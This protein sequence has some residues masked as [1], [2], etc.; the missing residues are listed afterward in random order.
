MTQE[1]NK[2]PL[3]KVLGL[4]AAGSWIV[5]QVVDVLTQNMGLPS[6]VFSFAVVLLVLGLP[7]VGATAYLSGLRSGTTSDGSATTSDRGA[8][9]RL[10]TW[11]NAIGGGVGALAL[12]GVV[13]A[14][15]MLF[16][17]GS[18]ARVTEA[19]AADLR[20]VAV[21]PFATR[22]SSEDDRYFTEGMHDDV[23]TQLSKI[24]SLKVISRTSV[25]Q[26]ADGMKPI[27]EIAAELGVATVLEG[28]VDRSGERVRVNVQLIEAA[29]DK[30]LWAETYDEELTAVN[31]FAI[32]SDLAMKIAGALRTTL[33]PEAEARIEARPTESLEA[34]DLYARGRYLLETRGGFGE[35]VDETLA[36]FDQAIATDSTFAPA[37]VGRADTY[38]SA[39]NW[40]T[41]TPAVARSAT[42]ESV[43]RALSLD[44]ELAE[45]HVADAR[46]AQMDDRPD[47]ALAA[48]ERAL[49]LNPGLADAHAR[50]GQL[51]EQ[52]GR[53]T[54]ALAE[55]RK[56]VDLDPLSVPSR[57]RLADRLWYSG[58]YEASIEESEKILEMDAGTWYAWYNI[59]WGHAMLG[60][61]DEAL[62]AFG[63]SL[64][65]SPDQAE[66][67]QLG[68]AYVF[69]R[70]GRADSALA[71]V[72][73]IPDESYDVSVVYYLAGDPERAFS[74][75]EEALRTDP[76]QRMRMETDP[77]AEPLIADARYG[78]LLERLGLR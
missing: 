15:W 7:I 69:A 42:A 38:L 46:L 32:R 14:G 31:V 60:R 74:S 43:E 53:Y 4:Y 6:W 77:S 25:M 3:W 67:I 19:E 33:T 71:I 1:T 28:G 8:P 59:G 34:F 75:L 17:P 76:G 44:P 78:P 21:L 52:M 56:A 40:R 55:A 70:Y 49:E 57:N 10:F 35:M 73:D 2:N 11:R 26:Y 61:T 22:S 30:H 45:A 54:E 13:A 16:G 68:R 41:I 48:I 12:W 20:S 72:S 50:L 24:D 47:D 65:A 51:L 27:P 9:S 18:G 5:M 58:Q 37:W 36:L 29:T 62:A 23:L 63:A 64:D 39:W 66:T